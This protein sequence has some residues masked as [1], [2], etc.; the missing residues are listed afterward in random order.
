MSLK[1]LNGRKNKN[2]L[3]DG[4]QANDVV[5]ANNSMP[6]LETPAGVA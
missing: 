4:A 3:S 6:K 5:T 2:G 1:Y